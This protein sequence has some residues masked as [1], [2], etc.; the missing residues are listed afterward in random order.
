M[1]GIRVLFKETR[2]PRTFSCALREVL[3]FCFHK[4]LRTT[5]A[6]AAG[7]TKRLWEIGEILGCA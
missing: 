5:L 4:T 2:K 6:M 3:Q 1:L 7:I